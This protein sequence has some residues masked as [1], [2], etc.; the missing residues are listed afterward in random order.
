MVQAQVAQAEAL[1]GAARA[2]AR[3][4]IADLWQTLLAGDEPS[5]RQRARY[6]LAITQAVQAA[7]LMCGAA[8][9][10]A[11]YTGS[12]LERQF[13]DIHTLAQHAALASVTL[14]P[15]APFFITHTS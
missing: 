4:V 1:V 11:V 3:E 5:V 6:R 2:F 10:R 12:P 15:G 7:D 13:H 14:E 9:G 8:G